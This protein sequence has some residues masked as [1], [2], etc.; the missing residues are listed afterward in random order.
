MFV[1]V[2]AGWW[3]IGSTSFSGVLHSHAPATARPPPGRSI[4]LTRFL[5]FLPER[6]SPVGHNNLAGVGSNGFE[7]RW[8]SDF[9]WHELFESRGSTPRRVRQMR[10]MFYEAVTGDP[11]LV[12]PNRSEPRA[13]KRRPK[14]V[15]LLT[16]PRK[17]MPPAIA[18]T[19]KP[20]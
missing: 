8:L 10:Q 11:L 9:S 18:K 7:V 17:Q 2:A 14:N 12:R 13:A 6:G 3:A 15:R 4:P 16:K 19:I 5:I 1:L 20:V